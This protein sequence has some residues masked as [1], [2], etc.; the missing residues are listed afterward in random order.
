MKQSCNNCHYSIRQSVVTGQK[1]FSPWTKS[2][3][4]RGMIL[5]VI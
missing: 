5:R 2:K 1:H 4:L 3:L